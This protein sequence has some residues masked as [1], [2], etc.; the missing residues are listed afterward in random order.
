MDHAGSRLGTIAIT[1]LVLLLLVISRPAVAAAQPAVAGTPRRHQAA[2]DLGLALL[3]CTRTGGWVRADGT[4]KGG[5]TGTSSALLP[6]LIRND[7]VSKKVAFRWASE[8]IAADVCDHVLPGRPVLD[9]RFSTAGF[10]FAYVGENVGCGWG[11]ASAEEVVIATHR[12]MQAE[13]S[14]GGWHWR[15]MKDRDF[16]GV[17][18]GVATLDGRTTI[19]YDFYGR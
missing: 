3:N 6:E 7:A 18:I 11:S 17:G 13:K 15:N 12:S 5:G 1:L 16:M 9:T 19:V 2:E 10:R 4:C 14:T 8:I